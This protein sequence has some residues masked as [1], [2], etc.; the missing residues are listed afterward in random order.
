MLRARTPSSRFAR[1]FPAGMSFGTALSLSVAGHAV[2][3]A[4]HFTFPDATRRVRDNALDIILV[5]S[6]SAHRPTAAQARAQANLDGGGNTDEA[7]RATTPLPPSERVR[8]G[9]DLVEAKRR[10]ASLE[11]RQQQMLTQIRSQR[12][13]AAEVQRDDPAP[14]APPAISGLDMADR[15]VAIARLEAQIDRQ[16][17]EYNKRPRKKFIGTRA[18]EYVAAQYLEDWRLKIERIGNLNYPEAAKGRLYG[19][20][21]VYVEINSS[22]DLERAEIRRSS[23]HKILDEA[24]LRIVRLAA[25]FGGFSADL[26]R[27]TDILAFARTWSFTRADEMK[28]SPQ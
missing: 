2:L 25:P 20:L 3:L 27:E 14:P 21:I 12:A 9:D 5:N 16:V 7:R 1:L 17:D 11:T 13:V 8:E 10:L 15:A 19:S 4:V 24:A 18:D 6:K 23:G 28:S 22:G 26:K